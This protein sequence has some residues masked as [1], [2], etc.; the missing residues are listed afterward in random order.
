MS[1][2]FSGSARNP[3][4]ARPTQIDSDYIHSRASQN[5]TSTIVIGHIVT[6][7]AGVCV[8]ELVPH[9]GRTDLAN[10]LVIRRH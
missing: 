3:S 4:G 5:S 9:T 10:R 2:P 8:A 1:K 6:V 7:V